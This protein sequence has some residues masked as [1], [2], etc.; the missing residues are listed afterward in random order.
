MLLKQRPLTVILLLPLLAL[1]TAA[2]ALLASCG[3][4]GGDDDEEPTPTATQAAEPTKPA[5]P[6]ATTAVQPTATSEPEPTEVPGVSL[7]AVEASITVDGDNADWAD[8]TGID[9]KLEQIT[10]PAGSDWE[11]DGEVA[12]KDAVLKVATDG[13]NVYVLLDVDDTYDYVADDHGLSAALGIMFQIENAA[14]PHMGSVAEDLETGL[15][16]VD[17]WHWELDCGPGV[18]AGGGDPGSGDDPDCNLDDEYATDPETR[19]DDDQ[20]GAENSL[21]GAWS[22]T[23]S[24]IGGNGTWIFEMARP[25]NTNDPTDAQLAA[26]GT[27]KMAIAFWDPKETAG[28]WSDAGHVTSAEMGWIEVTLP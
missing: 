4:G 27:V 26:G 21:S 2:I 12:P 18:L 6:T 9:L 28:G 17:I 25:L 8:I 24:T 11:V 10:I 19:E 20:A 1:A 3:G 14:G 7:Q 16:M 22:H 5:E 13:E 15:G 23:A